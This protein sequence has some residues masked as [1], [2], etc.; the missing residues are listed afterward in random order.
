MQTTSASGPATAIDNSASGRHP[1][2]VLHDPENVAKGSESNEISRFT[3][4]DVGQGK[5]IDEQ[6]SA[7]AMRI[8][9]S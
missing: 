9:W 2:G 4:H 5:P 6:G 1:A 8:C 7:C 3:A